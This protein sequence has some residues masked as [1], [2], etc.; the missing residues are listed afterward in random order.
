MSPLLARRPTP[1]LQWFGHLG[2]G[3]VG[4]GTQVTA[5]FLKGK[6]SSALY[7]QVSIKGCR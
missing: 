5:F 4:S 7:A 6:T 3:L 1:G 2:S